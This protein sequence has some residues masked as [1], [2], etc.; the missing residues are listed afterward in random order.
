MAELNTLAQ[1]A[2]QKYVS[3]KMQPFREKSSHVE[4]PLE[5]KLVT[6]YHALGNFIN[7]TEYSERFS[8]VDDLSIQGDPEFPGRINVGLVFSTFS[9]VAESENKDEEGEQTPAA[10][11]AGKS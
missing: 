1:V 4:L 10:S 9:F 11:G 7:M 5:I 2:G 3:M 6:D 8:K